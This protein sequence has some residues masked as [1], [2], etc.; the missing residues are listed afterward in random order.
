MVLGDQ[1][2]L[3]EVALFIYQQQYALG[4]REN[5]LTL[6]YGFTLGQGSENM[7]LYQYWPIRD[8]FIVT[9]NQVFYKVDIF[10]RGAGYVS[11]GLVKQQYI[12]LHSDHDRQ[13]WFLLAL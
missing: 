4:G 1:E 5:A 10:L 8:I 2:P 11:T 3:Y 9:I 13:R 12:R 7:L 6:I